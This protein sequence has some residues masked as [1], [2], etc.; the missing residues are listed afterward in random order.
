P[1][2]HG[3]YLSMEISRQTI[4]ATEAFKTLGLQCKAVSNGL[5]TFISPWI[6]G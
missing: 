3:W 1:S 2:F 4:G 6:D 5:Q